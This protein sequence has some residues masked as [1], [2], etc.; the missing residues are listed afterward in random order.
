[1]DYKLEISKLRFQ[2]KV[3][4]IDG[5]C[6]EWQSTLF[7][8]SGYGAFRYNNKQTLAHRTGWLFE[9]GVAPNG[10]LLHS[11]DNKICVNPAHLKE[12][13][14]YENIHDMIAKG[15]RVLTFA[16]DNG[17]S[18]LTYAQAQ[19]LRERYKTEGKP[20]SFYATEYG[21]NQSVI[22]RIIQGKTYN[23]PPI[24]V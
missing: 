9:K 13:T 1:M 6:W 7:Q 11:C 8:T 14:Q 10:I 19:E 5:G 2:S 21:V 17:V 18:K 24:R 15:R 20:Q 3:K 4:K 16:E 23:T 22:S 12:G